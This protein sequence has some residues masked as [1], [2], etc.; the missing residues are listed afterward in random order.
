MLVSPHRTEMRCL[1]L[2]GASGLAMLVGGIQRA[3]AIPSCTPSAQNISTNTASAATDGGSVS[4]GAGVTLGS[5]SVTGLSAALCDATSIINSGTVIGSVGVGVEGHTVGS[6]N[7]AGSIQGDG[8][9]GVRNSGTFGGALASIGAIVNTGMITGAVGII[10]TG[11]TI[12][13]S[14]T[15][16]V[17]AV[18]GSINNTG[19]ISGTGGGVYNALGSIGSLVNTGTIIG[20]GGSFGFGGGSA[21][22]N[23]VGTIGLLDNSG[24]ISIGGSVVVIGNYAGLIGTLTNTG[25]I[26]GGGTV[27]V[28]NAAFG[29]GATAGGATIGA[30][31][32]GGLID[33]GIGL[34]N[35]GGGST[36]GGSIAA[37]ATIGALTNTG[38]IN[39]A[40]LGVGNL[41]LSGSIGGS[42]GSGATIGALTNGGLIS[43]GGIGVLNAGFGDTVTSSAVIGTLTNTGTIMGGSVG[44]ANLGGN[45]NPAQTGASASIGT[46]INSGLISDGGAGGWGIA[47]SGTILPGVIAPGASIGIIINSG[48]ISGSIGI[49]NSSPTNSGGVYGASIGS[50]VNSGTISGTETGIGNQGGFIGAISNSGTITGGSFAIASTD[51]GRIGPVTNSGTILGNVLVDGQNLTIVGGSGTTFGVLTG[52]TISV[53]GGDLV[54]ASGNQQLVSSVVVNGGTGNLVNSGN[55]L[56]ASPVSLTGNYTQTSGGN[57]IIALAQE[58][59]GRLNLTGTA[60]MAGAAV[61]VLPLGG[62]RLANNT[63]ITVVDSATPAGTNYANVVATATGYRVTAS[64]ETV[65]DHYNLV[66]TLT[67]VNYAE[68][69]GASGSRPGS[70]GRTLDQLANSSTPE[71][72]AFQRSVLSAIDALPSGRAQ[73]NAVRA[74]APFQGSPHGLN[75]SLV[76]NIIGSTVEAH[77]LGF[78]SAG[79]APGVAAGSEASGLRVWAQ[80][81]GG[82]ASRTTSSTVDGYGTSHAGMMVGLDYAPRPNLLLG[83]GVS[84][85]FSRTEM[86][87]VSSGGKVNQDTTQFVGYGTYQFTPRLFAFGQAGA[88]VVDYRQTRAIPFAGAAARSAYDGQVYHAKVGVG[89][90]YQVN[91]FTLTPMLGLQYARSTNASYTETGAGVLNPRVSGRSV[92]AL[93]HDIGGRVTTEIPTPHGLVTPE[94]KLAW[95]HDYINSAIPT[96]GLLAGT[97]FAT[98]TQRI[99][100]N[101]ARVNLAAT[102]AHHS[103]VQI[104]LAYEGDLRSNFQGHTGLLRA[105]MPF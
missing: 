89:H 30:L 96:S 61:Q 17:G 57:L 35:V 15:G 40:F 74:T 28:M 29:S 46:I 37:G 34:L 99:S 77:Q 93:T 50:I 101:G 75:F 63:R 91:A 45:G 79:S 21:I 7:N 103:G 31:N 44:V 92:D 3:E 94:L 73:Q 26:A 66:L 68:I 55:L 88:G 62:P 4:I 48:T 6:I 72:L 83:A 98:S 71:A 47:N 52:G 84:S 19:L 10:N 42:V 80:A 60:S 59:A 85:V 27:S 5:G 25:T 39:G 20:N 64:T 56:L 82:V 54:L 90:D 2:A 86:H 58:S 70:L 22:T 81:M 87:G 9:A 78:A 18:I 53:T 95:T 11:D 13:A 14:L 12:G 102:L 97:G 1:L 49:Y 8:T 23:V 16:S 67:Q 33:G 32:N 41:D 69:G 38:T 76:T 51:G 43:G 65:A 104:R 24:L 36:I 100:A 105:S